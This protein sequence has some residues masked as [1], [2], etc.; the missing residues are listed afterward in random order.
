MFCAICHKQEYA[1]SDAPNAFSKGRKGILTN[2]NTMSLFNLAW[3]SSF[4]G[5]A[6]H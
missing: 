1:F 2:R 6:E 4:F 3:Y 5:M